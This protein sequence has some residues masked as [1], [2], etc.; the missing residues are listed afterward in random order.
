MNVLII[1]II[2]IILGILLTTASAIAVNTFRDN[3][4]YKDEH[5]GTYAFVVFILII[6]ILIICASVGG[7]AMHLYWKYSDTSV[8]DKFRPEK[9]TRASPLMEQQASQ[10]LEDILEEPV[11]QT[12]EKT[13]AL[14]RAF[15]RAVPRE[16]PRAIQRV[17]P[18]ALPRA[19]QRVEP[20][21]QFYSR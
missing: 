6:S 20:M 5:S 2:G 4:I 9:I 21:T 16:M 11:T 14:E 13:Q 15:P 3:E 18:R 12:L 8:L 17:E 10:S 19:I 7:I 1:S